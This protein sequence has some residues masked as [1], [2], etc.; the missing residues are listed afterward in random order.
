VYDS[1]PAHAFA[2]RRV[3]STSTGGIN[4][5][6]TACAYAEAVDEIDHFGA[7]VIL[8]V[9]MAL[10]GTNEPLEDVANNFVIQLRK[11][12]LVNLIDQSAPV[13]NCKI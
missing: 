6:L 13:A 12:K 10:I 1:A 3:R 7:G 11:I 4:D 2:R 5:G 9:F 8:A